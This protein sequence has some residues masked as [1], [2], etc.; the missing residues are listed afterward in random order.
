MKGSK[1]SFFLRN[2]LLRQGFLQLFQEIWCKLNY[3]NYLCTV[4]HCEFILIFI[5]F[6]FSGHIPFGSFH[7]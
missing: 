5:F 2:K 7:R 3:I 1:R 6:V 4:K